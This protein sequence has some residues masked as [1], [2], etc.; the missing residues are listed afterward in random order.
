M[1]GHRARKRFGQNFLHDRNVIDRILAAIAARPDDHVVEIGPGQG[2]LTR[3]LLET[4]CRLTLIEIDRDLARTLGQDPELRRAELINADAL[5]VDLAA[6]P[7]PPLRLIGNL[8][9]NV[10]TPLLFHALEAAPV[11]R[12]MHFMLQKEVVDR[13]AAAPGGREYGRLSVMLQYHCRVEPLF[14]VR[15]GS[16][17]PVP[18][19]QS[20]VVRLTPRPDPTPTARSLGTLG[21]IV[22]QAFGQRRK[23]I[24]NALKGSIDARGLE[25]L[26]IDPGLRAERL[27]VPDYVAIA[28]QVDP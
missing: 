13:M 6:L 2:A 11:L 16:F 21:R 15:P 3:G 4:G 17:H 10:S 5:D 25:A 27:S 14:V 8:P 22:T 28:N 23:T 19:V 12:D 24:A 26:G 1:S 18:R 9:Y 7:G 20:A